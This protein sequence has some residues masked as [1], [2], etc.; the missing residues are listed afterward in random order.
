MDAAALVQRVSGLGPE[1]TRKVKAK[2]EELVRA[3]KRKVS[4]FR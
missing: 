4:L 2:A 1:Q 3:S